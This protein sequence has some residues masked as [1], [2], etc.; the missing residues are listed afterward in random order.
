MKKFVATWE[1]FR[2]AVWYAGIA[3]FDASESVL[4]DNRKA[5]IN[6][7]GRYILRDVIITTLHR[8]SNTVCC[9]N[10]GQNTK[11]FFV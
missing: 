8:K 11:K 6:Q 10:S 9:R 2:L 4:P 7:I 3:G 5:C 1:K